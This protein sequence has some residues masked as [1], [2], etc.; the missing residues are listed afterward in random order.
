MNC[1]IDIASQIACALASIVAPTF[2]LSQSD[3]VI[4]TKAND[5]LITSCGFNIIKH[6]VV[7]HP[8]GA[9]ILENLR[10]TSNRQS[11]LDISTT[12]IPL[13]AHECGDM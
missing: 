9:F 10:P 13:P 1:P 2:G 8:L 5:I 12:R 3:I 4:V 7:S 6:I 11:R